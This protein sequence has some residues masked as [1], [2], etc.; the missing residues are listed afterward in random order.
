MANNPGMVQLQHNSRPETILLQS[1][2]AAAKGT[3]SSFAWGH[4]HGQEIDSSLRERQQLPDSSSR[5]VSIWLFQQQV[6]HQQLFCVSSKN[7]K[8]RTGAGWTQPTEQNTQA[9][10]CNSGWAV[11]TWKSVWAQWLWCMTWY[12]E[13]ITWKL[14]GHPVLPAVTAQYFLWYSRMIVVNSLS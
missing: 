5:L 7:M 6:L 9:E 2:Q 4:I 14:D 11:C 1:M 3:I 12:S 13:R 8:C 10:N